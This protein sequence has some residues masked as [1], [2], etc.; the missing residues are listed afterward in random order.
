M[1]VKLSTELVQALRIIAS[2]EAIALKKPDID[3][4]LLGGFITPNYF[5]GWM[6]NSK[7]RQYL[8]QNPDK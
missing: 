2:K 4:L 8:K 7:G 6:L 5:G 3:K 1:S